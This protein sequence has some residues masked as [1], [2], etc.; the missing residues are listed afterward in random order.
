MN[1]SDWLELEE[2]GLVPPTMTARE[3]LDLIKKQLMMTRQNEE[4]FEIIEDALPF[5]TNDWV[6]DGEKEVERTCARYELA[7][8]ED[9]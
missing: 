2:K 9:D 8:E 4:L 6:A 3:A 5:D 7:E 1:G